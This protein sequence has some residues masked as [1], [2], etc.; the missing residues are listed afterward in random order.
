VELRREEPSRRGER[1]LLGEEG[2]LCDWMKMQG[3]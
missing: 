3:C 1:D 2:A